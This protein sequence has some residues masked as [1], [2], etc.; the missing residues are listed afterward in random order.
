MR[1]HLAELEARVL[2]QVRLRAGR[3]LKA[4]FAPR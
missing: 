4:V 3:D 2:E 1:R